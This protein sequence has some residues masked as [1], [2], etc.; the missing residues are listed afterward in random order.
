ME[1]T[2]ID[3]ERLNKLKVGDTVFTKPELRDPALGRDKAT[4]TKV[5]QDIVWVS[6]NGTE[7]G[8]HKNEKTGVPLYRSKA[9][10]TVGEYFLDI[11][12]FTQ[13]ED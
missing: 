6:L 1:T 7:Y 9:G 2:L 4:V 3:K 13:E 10:E 11:K 5:T 8:L 12:D